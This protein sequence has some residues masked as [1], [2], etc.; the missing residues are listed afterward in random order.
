M[1]PGPWERIQWMSISGN[2]ECGIRAGSDGDKILVAK[3]IRFDDEAQLIAAAPDMLDAL[4]LAQQSLRH[5]PNCI[6]RPSEW[7]AACVVPIA[8]EKAE[9]RS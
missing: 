9:A 2:V 3:G 8:I 7:C 4:K 1:T 5:E 6:K